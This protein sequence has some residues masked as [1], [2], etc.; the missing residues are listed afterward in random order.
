VVLLGVPE[1]KLSKVPLDNPVIFGALIV[2]VYK[3]FAGT[4]PLAVFTGDTVNETPLQVTR[5]IALMAAV[6]LTVTVKVNELFAPQA[7]LVGVIVYVA[8]CGVISV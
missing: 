8:V 7:G 1:M 5:V 4:L 2:Q 6:G 3:V